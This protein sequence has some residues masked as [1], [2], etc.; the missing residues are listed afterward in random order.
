MAIALNVASAGTNTTTSP[1]TWSHTCTGSNLVL[2]VAVGC[3]AIGASISTP[4]YNGVSMTLLGSQRTMTASVVALYYLLNPAAGSNTISVAFGGT[5]AN[6][7][8][9]A[10]SWTGV[11]QTAQPDAVSG[12]S[13][14]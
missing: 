12:I 2:I 6:C 11:K 5:S 4:T 3:R 7:N 10:V 13:D 9:G 14:Q 1:L 8:G